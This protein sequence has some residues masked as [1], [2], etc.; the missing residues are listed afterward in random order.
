MVGVGVTF[1]LRELVARF[2]PVSVVELRPFRAAAA[3]CAALSVEVVLVGVAAAVRRRVVVVVV[4]G[5]MTRVATVND[6]VGAGSSVVEPGGLVMRGVVGVGVPPGDFV[7][8]VTPPAPP[9]PP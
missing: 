6:S 1:F 7:S 2:R 4:D 3:F 8:L 5:E 9:T